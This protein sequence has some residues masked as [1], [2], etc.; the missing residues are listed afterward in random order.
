MTRKPKE[1]EKPAAEMSDQERIDAWRRK[2]GQPIDTP[3]GKY[4]WGTK[5]SGKKESDGK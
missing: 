5:S 1:P 4:K 3:K 2:R